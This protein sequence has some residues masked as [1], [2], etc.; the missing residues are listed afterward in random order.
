MMDWQDINAFFFVW[1]WALLLLLAIPAFWFF[2]LRKLRQQWRT[3]A[4]SFS[5]TSVIEQLKSQP[6]VWKRFLFPI[7]VSLLMLCFILGLARPTITA[8]VPVNSADIMMVLDISLSMLAEDIKPSRMDAARE[9]AINFVK[10]LPRD[11]RIG[12]EFF[13]GDTYVASPPTSEHQEIIAYLKALRKEDLK[14]R[15]E[16]GSALRAATQ[17]L[18]RQTEQ[19]SQKKEKDNATANPKA[20]RKPD[21]VIVLLSDGD[22][23]E[24]FP[25]DMAARQAKQ[26]N[27]TVHTIGVGSLAGSFITYQGVELPVTFDEQTLRQTATL[28][29]G[30]YFRVFREADFKKVYDQIQQRTIHYEQHNIDLAFAMAGAGLLILLGG[31]CLSM[32]FL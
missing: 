4:L 30:E 26:A 29:G 15:T 10:S 6:A 25:W 22:S 24:G 20:L 8:K 28:G 27:I 18:N 16:I 5:Y 23:H 17:I 2:Y 7:S 32:V 3:L 19:E 14:Q 12:L 11:A 13:A 21:R 31:L 1:P 9:A